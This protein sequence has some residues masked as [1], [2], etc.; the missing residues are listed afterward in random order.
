MDAKGKLL[1]GKKFK[2]HKKD[3][4]VLYKLCNYQIRDWQSCRRLNID[5]HKGIL[6]SG[7]VGCGKTSLMKFIRYITPQ[8][9]SFE[10]IPTRNVAFAFNHIGYKIIE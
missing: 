8:F 5:I 2:I 10:L 7:S 9:S 3:Q 4:E 1:F 6:L